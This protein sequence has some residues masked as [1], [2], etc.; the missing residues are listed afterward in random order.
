M[1]SRAA[2]G[3]MERARWDKKGQLRSPGSAG[4]QSEFPLDSADGRLPIFQAGD[5]PVPRCTIV[6]ATVAESRPSPLTRV[7]SRALTPGPRP[8]AGSA[9]RRTGDGAETRRPAP[10]PANGSVNRPR[11][12]RL[13]LGRQAGR[14]KLPDSGWASCEAHGTRVGTA[15]T[16]VVRLITRRPLK[17]VRRG[18][19]GSGMEG[20]VIPS[21]STRGKPSR[22]GPRRPCRSSGGTLRMDAE[23][24]PLLSSAGH[25]IGL[26][27]PG[28]W[29]GGST[30]HSVVL[31]QHVPREAAALQTEPREGP[32]VAGTRQ[33]LPMRPARQSRKA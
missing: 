29:I 1:V 24:G 30:K 27:V 25:L 15:E 10:V 3:Q 6:S 18:C 21:P 13:P 23:A 17:C 5:L 31:L 11:R 8:Q 9:T 4:S 20:L 7:A 12:D 19:S 14:R 2:S 32:L 16:G 28:T 26:G 33:H 22:P